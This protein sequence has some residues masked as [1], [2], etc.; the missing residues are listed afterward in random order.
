MDSSPLNVISKASPKNTDPKLLE[1]SDKK[2]FS[3][4]GTVMSLRL[5]WIFKLTDVILIP[6]PLSLSCRASRTFYPP[7]AWW[8]IPENAHTHRLLCKYREFW[9]RTH[10]IRHHTAHCQ[11]LSTDSGPTFKFPIPIETDMPLAEAHSGSRHRAK[12]KLAPN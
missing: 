10:F 8:C 2:S 7:D 11:S 5:Y 3:G 9:S 6:P 12:G 1:Q 4:G